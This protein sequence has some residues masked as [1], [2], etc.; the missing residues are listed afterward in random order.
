MRVWDDP[1][2]INSTQR[3]VEVKVLLDE[4]YSGFGSTFEEHEKYLPCCAIIQCLTGDCFYNF[5]LITNE[6]VVHSCGYAVGM[7]KYEE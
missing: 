7:K 4:D 5:D 6:G 3:N 1:L 2:K